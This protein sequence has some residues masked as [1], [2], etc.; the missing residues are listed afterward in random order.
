MGRKCLKCL[1]ETPGEARICGRCGA[2]IPEPGARPDPQVTTTLG[3]ASGSLS[4][5]VL[6]AG[7]YL[8]IDELGKGGMGCVYR[9]LDTSV[10]EE[11]ALKFLNP[12]VAADTKAIERFRT[13]L[14]IT[15]KIAHHNVCRLYDLGQEGQSLFITMEYIP[16]EDLSHMIMRLGRLPVEKGFSIARQVC[17]GLAEV[18]S[19]G[20]IHRDL[21]PKNIMIDKEGRAKITDF[22]LARTSH[23]VRLTEAGHIV[24]TPS[25]MSPEQLDGEAVDARS[26]IFSFG[27]TMYVMLTGALPFDADTT[28]ALAL[29]H[30]TKRPPAPQVLNPR[31]PEDL[32]RIILKCLT[33]DR[34]ARY[35]SARDL[36]ADLQKAGRRFETYAFVPK[37]PKTWMSKLILLR[38]LTK[39]LAGGAVVLLVTGSGLGIRSLLRRP[40]E[41]PRSSPVLKVEAPGT[42]KQEP[43][44]PKTV[45]TTLVTTP[46]RAAVEV[47]GV[48]RGFS[49][50]T[51]DLDPGTYTVRINKTGYQQIKD[52]LVVEAGSRGSLTREFKL[53]P[54]PPATGTLLITSDPSDANV[55]IGDSEKAAGRT[56][57]TKEV[58]AGKARIRF[59]LDGY[60]E[61][62]QEVEV[63]T[64]DRSVVQ[65]SLPPLNGTVQ[66]SSE[67][68]GAGVYYG[69]ELIGTTPFTQSLAP[70]DYRIRIVWKGQGEAE[71]VITVRPG[72]TL[73]PP[74][75]KLAVT[76]PAL[77]YY[78]KITS[79]PPG[80]SVTINGKMLKEL[81][82]LSLEL[83]T[84]EVRI[85]VEKEG[86][87]SQ[88]EVIYIRPAPAHNVQ[89]FDLKKLKGA[90]AGAPPGAR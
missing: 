81:T 15:R 22:G 24:G 87:K 11:V 53:T 23:G 8:V 60:Q 31:V 86:F 1:F 42:I 5:G 62:A 38:P 68:Q 33:I 51:F 7:R 74:A 16:G 67:P 43:L 75:Y 90:D 30:R 58:P 28:T 29:Q 34:A 2:A 83:D 85:R 41:Q 37:T 46:S 78:L 50:E 14:R 55:F 77:S 76:M 57:L 9:A 18:H 13:E 71:D 82:P 19:M 45:R 25:F 35:P 48:S 26:D 69:N 32:S 70:A 36:L 3:Y 63:R 54:L 80:A 49:G 84:H 59:S 6:F 89:D 40:K 52:T 79:D 10:D 66:F 4:D 64:G 12:D 56:P 39:I 65:V 44:P 27:I 20:V 73:A 47:D 17:E 88:E 61:Q 21:K 72:E